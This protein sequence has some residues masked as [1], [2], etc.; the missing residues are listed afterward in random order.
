[1]MS[2]P[3]T[4]CLLV[5]VFRAGVVPGTDETLLNDTFEDDSCKLSESSSFGTSTNSNKFDF[6]MIKKKFKSEPCRRQ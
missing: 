6:L 3:A 1:M 4:G 2:S 5:I